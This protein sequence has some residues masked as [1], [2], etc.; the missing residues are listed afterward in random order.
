MS[1]P[2][3]LDSEFNVVRLGEIFPVPALDTIREQV[4][5]WGRENF[6]ENISKVDPAMKLESLAPLIGI[7]E[8][9]GESAQASTRDEVKDALADVTIYLCD[10]VTREGETFK[11][12]C[13]TVSVQQVI[14]D[15]MLRSANGT[16]ALLVG[17]GCLA[18]ATLKRH[19]GIRNFGD[20][21]VYRK[22]R[23]EGVLL[24]L[25]GLLMLSIDEQSDLLRIVTDTWEKVVAKRNW[26]ANAA[27]ADKVAV[28]AVA[29]A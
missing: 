6:G 3:V 11:S 24:A 23:N 4:S 8:E 19:Q 22:K 17:Q 12:I 28:A 10:Y 26:K 13:D 9:I 25:L 1:T 5:A 27:S 16:R 21:K 29:A 7:F 2:A 20:D 14:Y 18:H 15:Y